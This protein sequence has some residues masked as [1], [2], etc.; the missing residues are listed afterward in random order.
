MKVFRNKI[1]LSVVLSHLMVDLLNGGRSVL[2]TYLSGILYLTN[3]AVG[4]YSMLYMVASAI[5]QPLFG[6]LTDR[7]GSRWVVTGGVLWIG[8][9][10]SIAM[11]VP[12]SWTIF[13]MILGSVGSGAFHPAG[14]AQ[15]TLTGKKYMDGQEASAASYFFLFGE[16]GF[17]FGPILA[18]ALIQTGGLR[19]MLSLSIF[20][21][22]VGLFAVNSLARMAPERAGEESQSGKEAARRRSMGIGVIAALVLVAGLQSWVQQ[23]MIVFLPKYLSDLGQTAS[24]YGFS[25]SL[26]LGGSAVGII[27]GG[28]IADEYG[29][30]HVIFAGMILGIMPLLLIPSAGVTFWL[31]VLS[32]LGGLTTG[33]TYSSIIVLAQRLIPG[34]RGLASGLILGFVF[35]FGAVGTWISGA[36]ADRMG[37]ASVFTYTAGLCLLAGLL[38]LALFERKK[39]VV[40]P[41]VLAD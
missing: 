23:N 11:L 16:I 3:A 28:R 17:F 33:S 40:S 10:F 36:L 19:A 37:T 18:G 5:V 13:F 9:F 8:T 2:L 20:A 22:P 34:G 41:A 24:F 38:A 1:F 32:A 25:V 15:A 6:Y 21:I 7:F 35:G 26:F 31:F 4:F 29:K 30:P 12:P 14:A 39:A 27:I